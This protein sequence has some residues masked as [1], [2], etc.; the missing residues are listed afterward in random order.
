MGNDE[1]DERV[2]FEDDQRKYK[3]MSM[4]LPEKSLL[5][6]TRQ[7]GNVTREANNIINNFDH[8]PGDLSKIKSSQSFEDEDED[9][10]LDLTSDNISIAGGR[11]ILL[12]NPKQFQ[13]AAVDLLEIRKKIAE[14]D[15]YKI[16]FLHDM[17]VFI[18]LLKDQIM[19]NADFS[20]KHQASYHANM[21]ALTEISKYISEKLSK[22]APPKFKFDF[23]QDHRGILDLDDKKYALIEILDSIS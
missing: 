5:P 12:S 15:T 17:M 16:K 23:S 9:D 2:D 11:G 22:C 20:G 19:T 21:G 18:L 1:S 6:S 13:K 4:R 7:L 10:T 8:F 14:D 3:S